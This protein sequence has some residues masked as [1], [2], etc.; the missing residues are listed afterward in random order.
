LAEFILAEGQRFL[1]D[2]LEDDEPVSRNSRF[3]LTVVDLKR[4]FA[5]SDVTA[6]AIARA[7]YFRYVYN[8]PWVSVAARSFEAMRFKALRNTKKLASS[9]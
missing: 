1:T 9:S 6:T 5:V 8:C 4:G 2:L 3:D 7:K